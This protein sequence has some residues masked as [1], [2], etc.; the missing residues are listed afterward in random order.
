MNYSPGGIHRKKTRKS[1]VM[2]QRQRRHW[3]ALSLRPSRRRRRRR[4]RHRHCLAPWRPVFCFLFL[5][6]LI[7]IWFY[8]FSLRATMPP[9]HFVRRR[10][11]LL[12]GG[13]RRVL[14]R[15][16]R[17][18]REKES[19]PVTSSP[20]CRLDQS[21]KGSSA[22]KKRRLLRHFGFK[23]LP[24]LRTAFFFSK[25]RCSGGL[26]SVALFL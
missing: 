3:M 5:S 1:F 10:P 7:F 9:R 2:N 17:L 15:R 22:A 25:S 13:L 12:P 19:L 14:T 26:F 24:A 18:A 11:S 16:G 8:S 6:T 20:S 4:R 23:S 21:L